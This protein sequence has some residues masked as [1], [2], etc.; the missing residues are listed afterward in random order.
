MAV[1]IPTHLELW[2]K[3]DKS[4]KTID[5][6]RKMMSKKQQL[7]V[8]WSGLE[9]GFE[10]SSLEASHFLDT[11]T[12]QVLMVMSDTLRQLEEI[13]ITHYDAQK[14]K[15]F[16]LKAIL[17]AR[18]L[19]DWEQQM[20]L[21]ADMVENDTNGRFVEIPPFDSYEAYGVM[22][23]FID[24]VTDDRLANQLQRAI[25]GR[26]AFRRFKDVLEAHYRE[27]KRWFAF[28]S[29]H[30]LREVRTWLDH[31]G[32]EPLNEPP[33]H[34]ETEAELVAYRQQLLEEVL[35]FVQE[36]HRLP[37]VTRIALIGSLTTDEP[38]P[39]DIDMLVTV[40]VGTDLTEL[41]TVGRKLRGHA[42]SL[43]RGGDL[44]LADEQHNY[45]GRTCPWKRCEPGI[46][47][48]CEAQHCGQR[49]FLYDD[50]HVLRLPK[51]L[52]AQPPIE[53]WPAVV[54]R[55]AVPADLEGIVI[56]P[57]GGR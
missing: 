31:V 45:L 22:E 43:G 53:L 20:L 7:N 18:G 19:G 9:T 33:P 49:P 47:V 12:G 28:S 41:S 52:I 51:A 10:D 40:A 15:A 30:T 38:D 21:E 5:W 32:I 17:A 23:A 6:R 3:S 44:F 35:W 39:K 56:R 42:Q 34:G 54:S 46:R 29:E 13:Y 1:W 55:V 36:A 57:L 48:S 27:R 50:L 11:Q 8:D 2:Y 14:P 25:S 37:G 4:S 24:T 26:G 16:D